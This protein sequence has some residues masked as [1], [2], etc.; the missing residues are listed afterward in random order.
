[1]NN[2]RALSLCASIFLIALIVLCVVWEVWIAPL[3][4]GSLLALKAVP[5]LLPLRGVLHG[6][7]YTSQ[8]A[9]M[10]SLL[11]LSEGMLRFSDPGL[12]AVCARI[13]IALALA[14]FVS[15]VLHARAS[16]P[17]RQKHD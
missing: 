9:S 15:L 7:R 17:S 3:R 16:A 14:L 2:A 1:M 4:P 13:E 12:V 8:W 5:L 11:Y 10:L 6:R